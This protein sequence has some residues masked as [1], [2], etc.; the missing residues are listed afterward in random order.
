M[1]YIWDNGQD[2]SNHEINFI[3]TSYDQKTVERVLNGWG[4]GYASEHSRILAVAEALDWRDKEK[5]V[6]PLEDFIYPIHLFEWI[7]SERVSKDGQFYAL[8]EYLGTPARRVEA[9]GLYMLNEK[10]LLEPTEECWSRLDLALCDY[11]LSKWAPGE[12]ERDKRMLEI[13]ASEKTK[14]FEGAERK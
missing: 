3:E 4:H 9:A 11:L 12:S 1:I 8:A 7:A 10:T 2:Y 6:M 14:R 5:G 13:F